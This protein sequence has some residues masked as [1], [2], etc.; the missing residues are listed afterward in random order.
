MDERYIDSINPH[1]GYGKYAAI[2]IAVTALLAYMSWVHN[3]LYEIDGLRFYW[4]YWVS[5]V[6]CLLSI[7]GTFFLIIITHVQVIVIWTLWRER[8]HGIESLDKNT[9]ISIHNQNTTINE[10]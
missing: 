8:R 2:T 7:A 4:A 10:D 6:T 3:L 9:I 1:T 5:A